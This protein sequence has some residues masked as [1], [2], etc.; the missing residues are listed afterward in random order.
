VLSGPNP[1]VPLLHSPAEIGINHYN[2][3]LRLSLV[4][5]QKTDLVEFLKTL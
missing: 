3:V 2:T 5:Q 1:S 4:D